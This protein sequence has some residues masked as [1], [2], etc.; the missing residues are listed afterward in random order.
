MTKPHDPQRL[1]LKSSFFALG[2][3]ACA[4]GSGAAP[5]Q[6]L[7]S[8]V[9]MSADTGGPS[10][11]LV[12]PN[13]VSFANSDPWIARNHQH[14]IKMRPKFLVINFANGIGA[15]GND[16]VNDGP[17]PPALVQAKAQS[18]VTALREASRHQPA[19]N[20]TAQPFL[21]P[22]IVKI[23]D[24]RDSNGHANS[25]LFPRGPTDAQGY[26]EVGYYD[27]FS[28][29]YAAYWGF[30]ENGR[31]LTLGEALD[32]GLFHE[33]IML[34]N[35]V[36]GRAPNPPSQVTGHILEVAFTAQAYDAALVPLADEF[37]KNGIAYDRQKADMAKATSSDDNSM[38]WTGRSLRIY[39]MNAQRG[40]GCLMHSLGH[41]FEFRYNESRIYSPGKAYNGMPPNPYM[42]P[43]FRRYADFDM[44]TKYGVGFASLYAGGDNYSYGTCGSGACTNLHVMMPGPVGSIAN[45]HPVA[46]NVHYPPGA[47]HG[48]DYEPIDHVMSSMESFAKQGEAPVSFSKARWDYITADPTLDGDC[49]GKFLV[50]WYQ[51]MPGLNTQARD[52]QGNPMRNWW[53][54]MYY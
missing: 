47:T 9:D 48:Y 6:D 40:A 36:D 25:N 37:V 10:D 23:V 24:L 22:E 45:Y 52:T 1:I 39:F 20:A 30:Q 41:E 7:G 13:A 51:N 18:F 11:G 17:F 14:L 12:W 38:P 50:F 19:L 27:L 21:E 15:G 44:A 3:F 34:A 42:Q 28:T 16:N 53:P 46:G 33:I 49:G 31:N 29:R 43:L 32:R 4:P 5:S 35:Q 54:F 2:L 26:P 8:T